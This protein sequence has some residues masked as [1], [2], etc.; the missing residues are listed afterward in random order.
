MRLEVFS[1]PY[2]F[3]GPRPEITNVPEAWSY[4]QTITITSPQAGNIR[5]AS[6]IKNGATTHSFDSCQR[7]IDLDIQTQGGGSIQAVVTIN[8]NIAPPGW[9]MLFIID[10]QGI[11]SIARWIQLQED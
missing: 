2:L 4:G 9:Y 10:N 11:P 7:L 1:P 6:L 8:P 3:R 5:W